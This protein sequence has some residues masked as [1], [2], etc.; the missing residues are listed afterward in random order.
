M[1]NLARKSHI[2]E[3]EEVKL[4]LYFS[5]V[6]FKTRR[7][8]RSIS[9]N[10]TISVYLSSIICM[11][12]VQRVHKFEGSFQLD[13]TT[14]AFL[15]FFMIFLG[16]LNLLYEIFTKTMKSLFL[17]VGKRY[18]TFHFEVKSPNSRFKPPEFEFRSARKQN[19]LLTMIYTYSSFP[20]FFTCTIFSSS[21][22][23]GIW[24]AR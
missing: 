21:Q 15:P 4:A 6:I 7:G 8:D 5:T 19:P 24:Q 2:H 18:I 11:G 3:K 17:R 14:L 10:K 23:L 16:C 13:D 12:A 1:E 22:I 20:F 9:V